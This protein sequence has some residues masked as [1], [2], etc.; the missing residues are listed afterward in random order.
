MADCFDC[1]HSISKGQCILKCT[2]TGENVYDREHTCSKFANSDTTNVCEDCDYYE[3]GA[4]SR[5]NPN[6]KCKLT[7][8][9]KKQDDVACSSFN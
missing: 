5:W 1:V 2:R 4:F 6:G 3:F 7:G 8:K 9:S